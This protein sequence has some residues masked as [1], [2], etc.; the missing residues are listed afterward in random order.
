[1]SH[2]KF[3]ILPTECIYVSVWITEQTVIISQYGITGR[4]LFT[5]RYEQDLEICVRF[6]LVF[7][8]VI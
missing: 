4:S 7:R 8:E 5:A 3:C 2:Q 6:I 1:M